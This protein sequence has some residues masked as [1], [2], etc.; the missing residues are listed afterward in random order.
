MLQDYTMTKTNIELYFS[1]TVDIWDVVFCLLV[2]S[3][4]KLNILN[5]LDIC[6]TI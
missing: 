2:C 3:E 4:N 1:M 5:K 6:L